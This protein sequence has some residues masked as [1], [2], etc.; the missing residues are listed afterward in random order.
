M[1]TT[2]HTQGFS[3]D[4]LK[5]SLRLLLT[6]KIGNYFLVSN[7]GFELPSERA[8]SKLSENRPSEPFLQNQ[9]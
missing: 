6:M 9:F 5:L 3:D 1:M 8:P 7:L 4:V 2:Y